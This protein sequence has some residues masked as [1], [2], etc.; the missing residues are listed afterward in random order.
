MQPIHLEKTFTTLKKSRRKYN[1]LTYQ[2]LLYLLKR[3][4]DTPVL[5]TKN[6]IKAVKRMVFSV[7]RKTMKIQKMNT[8][9]DACSV[10][11]SSVL[12]WAIREQRLVSSDQDSIEFNIKLDGRPLGG[13]V[14]I[15]SK[16]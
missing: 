6:E 16:K 1:L 3:S 4:S 8:E 12:V 5:L 14:Y 13:A 7:V 15:N 9:F 10:D 2:S 11:L